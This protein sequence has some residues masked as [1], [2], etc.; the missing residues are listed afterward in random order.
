[1]A[2]TTAAPESR[3]PPTSASCSLPSPETAK[4]S[5][6]QQQQQQQQ[7]K[8]RK[9]QKRHHLQHQHQQKAEGVGECHHGQEEEVE[10]QPLL[11]GLPDHLAQLCLARLPPR[12]LFSLSRSWRR[13]LYSSSFPPFLSLYA[14]L[15]SNPSSSSIEL[16]AFDP[17]AA[18]WR[19]LPHHP[20]LRHL[21]LRHS[22][23]LSRPF[24]VQSVAVAGRL[25]LLSGTTQAL[26]PALPQPLV[27]H[28]STSRWTFGPPL[29]A[30]RR[31][32]AAGAAG[33]SVYVASG[34]G[35]VYSADVAR[36]VERW[37]LSGGEGCS[38]RGRRGSV[39]E[40]DRWEK[41]APLWDGRFSRDA[42]E[43]VASE[44]KLCMVNVKGKAAKEGAVYD[45]AFDLWENMPPGLLAGWTGPAAAAPVEAGGCSTIYVVDEVHD[46]YL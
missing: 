11:P 35:Y 15:S 42:V 2:C 28:P 14:L 34:V 33:G 40:A 38:G 39:A 44:G 10:Q 30:P 6:D 29:P 26:L 43:L 31:W 13:F 4:G 9:W 7:Q 45:L 25:V 37:D 17:V 41:V 46:Q 18:A 1:M 12:L 27:F 21:L 22:A 20:Q 32:C 24:P 16:Q 23:F 8:Q 19:P 3:N 5:H 36:S